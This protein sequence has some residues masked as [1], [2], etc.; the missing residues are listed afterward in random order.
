[1]IRDPLNGHVVDTLGWAE[2]RRD[3]KERALETLLRAN[4]LSP[5]EPEILLHIAEVLQALGRDEEAKSW[6]SQAEGSCYPG[7][8]A[9]KLLERKRNA[10]TGSS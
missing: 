1:M 5:R 9:W 2:F 4:D 6:F 10:I 3:Q 7:H 8:A